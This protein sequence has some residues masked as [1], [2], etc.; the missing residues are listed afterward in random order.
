MSQPDFSHPRF[1][2]TFNFGHVMMVVGSFCSV[3][4]MFVGV[5]W[6]ESNFQAKMENEVAINTK[7]RNDY[8]PIIHE[9]LKI[10][11]VTNSQISSLAN[12]AGAL[13]A[14]NKEQDASLA[15]IRER[16]VVI[17]SKI[18]IYGTRSLK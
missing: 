3:M 13:Q 18:K 4:A 12:S 5:V 17:E 14:V 9:M 16:L 6:W 7:A 1:D 10:Q 15:S 2:P 11:A 8:I